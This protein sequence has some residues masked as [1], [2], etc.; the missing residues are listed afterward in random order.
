MLECS[1]FKLVKDHFKY[2]LFFKRVKDHF[3]II[4]H[5]ILMALKGLISLNHTNINVLVIIPISQRTLLLL[6]SLFFN[7]TYVN[8]GGHHGHSVSIPQKNCSFTFPNYYTSN[9]PTWCR[10]FIGDGFFT[11]S[12]DIKCPRG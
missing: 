4:N 3:M 11:P 6:V 8:A 10:N 12:G 5:S 7:S 9:T 2:Q 1:F